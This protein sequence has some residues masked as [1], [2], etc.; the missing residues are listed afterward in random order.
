MQARAG[1]EFGQRGFD[2]LRANAREADGGIAA[3]GFGAEGRSGG[4]VAADMAAQQAGLSMVGQRQAAIRALRHVTAQGALQ[5]RRETPPV[6]KQQ[7]LLPPLQPLV[8][9]LLQF[10]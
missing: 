7:R 10:G 8:D 1:E 4:G 9:G 6:Q 3:L 2:F 5:G